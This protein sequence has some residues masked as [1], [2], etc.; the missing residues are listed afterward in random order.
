MKNTL[1]AF[2]CVA[3]LAAFANNPLLPVAPRNDPMKM[4]ENPK[5]VKATGGMVEISQ[6][7]TAFVFADARAAKSDISS[8]LAKMRDIC[9]MEFVT[10]ETKVDGCPYKQAKALLDDKSVGAVALVREGAADEPVLSSYP[11]DKVCVLNV[12]PLK[13]GADDKL[14]SE[15]LEKELWRAMCFA[16]G[17][18]SSGVDQ[19]VMNTVLSRKDLDDIP[20]LMAGPVAIGGIGRTAK[21]Y[22]FGR[23]YVMPYRSACMKG[24]AP[25]P[26]NEAQEAIWNLVMKEKKEATKEPTAPMKIKF[27]PKKGR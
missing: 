22:G 9:R 17:G 3:S 2:L 7:G 8:V 14:Y 19:C 24:I 21:R 4:N 18:C 1:L 11:E 12:T 25:K 23:H 20:C 10:R 26:A 5:F 15:R 16:A 13:V 27:D 6:P